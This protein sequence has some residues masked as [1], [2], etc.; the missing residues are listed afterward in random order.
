MFHLRRSVSGKWNEVLS[1]PPPRR[2]FLRCGLAPCKWHLPLLW[3]PCPQV[4]SSARQECTWKKDIISC[5][6]SRIFVSNLMSFIYLVMSSSCAFRF[7]YCI[8]KR[9]FLWIYCF[10]MI[11]LRNSGLP[12]VWPHCAAQPGRERHMGSHS[13]YLWRPPHVPALSVHRPSLPAHPWVQ[14]E[15]SCY[16]VLHV[17][18]YCVMVILLWLIL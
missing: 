8:Y 12:H 3:C 16:S 14:G 10:S 9:C 18:C 6:I 15:V 2:C 1:P 5:F 7:R 17:L 4:L 11:F 13:P